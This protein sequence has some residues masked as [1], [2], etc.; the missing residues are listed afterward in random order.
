M[1][2]RI[3]PF[4]LVGGLCAALNLVLLTALVEWAGWPYAVALVLAFSVSNVLGYQLNRR[5]AFACGSPP[6][7]GGRLHRYLAVM[8]VS[9]LLYLMFTAGMVEWARVRYGL[10]AVFMTGVM[11]FLNYNAHRWWTFR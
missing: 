8:S 10:A 3:A 5:L 11:T 7:S 6:M 2:R 4:L 1:S 9:A